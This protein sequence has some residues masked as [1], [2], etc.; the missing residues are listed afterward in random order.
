M[1]HNVQAQVENS[2]ALHHHNL[3][4]AHKVDH[5]VQAQVE[6]QVAVDLHR[7]DLAHV[8]ALVVHSEKC[9]Q[10]KELQE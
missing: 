5:N 8:P 10:E 9:R 6:N 4:I 7:E 1:E 3:L 2:V